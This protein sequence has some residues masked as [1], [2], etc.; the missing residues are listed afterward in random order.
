M[1]KCPAINYLPPLAD[2]DDCSWRLTGPN[3]F[4]DDIVDEGQL[5]FAQPRLHAYRILRYDRGRHG[6]FSQDT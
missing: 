6:L 3:C 4:L 2:Q 5:V 1:A